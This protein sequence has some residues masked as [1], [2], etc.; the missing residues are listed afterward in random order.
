MAARRERARAPVEGVRRAELADVP[1]LT[2]MLVRAYMDD[3]V[4]IWICGAPGARA[5]M[6]EAMYS[7]RLRQLL[8]RHAVWT[9]AE[10]SSAAVWTPPAHGDGAPA[11]SHGGVR[12]DAALLRRVLSP[13]ML[14]RAPLLALG[15]GTMQRRHPREPPHWYLVL[16]GTDPDARGHGLGSAMLQPV[17][18]RCD[19]E[20]VGAY[21]ESSKP[22]NLDFYARLG[23]R[24]VGELQLPRGPKM[25]PM[26]REPR[27]D[28]PTIDGHGYGLH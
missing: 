21:L 1:E 19:A 25:W 4:A 8:G 18:E 13:R 2:R 14:A 11:H 24:T 16:L 23:F 28:R 5:R 7:A 22:R 10:R 9:N 12:P 15:L 17:L 6:L 20:G 26:W 3:P 27:D